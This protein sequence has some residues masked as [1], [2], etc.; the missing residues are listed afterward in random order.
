MLTASFT[1]ASESIEITDLFITWPMFKSHKPA[2]GSPF[3]STP[4]CYGKVSMINAS[5]AIRCFFRSRTFSSPRQSGSTESNALHTRLPREWSVHRWVD[6]RLQ[7]IQISGGSQFSIVSK[8]FGSGPI[9]G[10]PPYQATLT[11]QSSKATPLGLWFFHIYSSDSLQDLSTCPT[12]IG[13]AR[14]CGDSPFGVYVDA[15][16]T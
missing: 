5:A 10:N 6:S 13:N 15:P 8:D 11:L 4:I 1:L 16:T 9:S 14:Y 12:T 2:I 3:Y 7:A